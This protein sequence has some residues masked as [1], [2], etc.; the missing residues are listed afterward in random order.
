MRAPFQS[1]AT[2]YKLTSQMPL[3]CLFRRSDRNQWQF[4]AGGGAYNETPLK[5]AFSQTHGQL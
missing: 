2:P 1:L 3:F 4:I 5:A